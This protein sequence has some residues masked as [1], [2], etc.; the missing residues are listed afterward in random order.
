VIL[1]ER[2]MKSVLARFKTYG[3]QPGEI[4]GHEIHAVMA[5]ERRDRPDKKRKS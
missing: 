3:K 1:S 2:E 4:E 5:P